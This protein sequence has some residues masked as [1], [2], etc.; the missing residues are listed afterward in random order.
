MNRLYIIL[1]AIVLSSC[2]K[3]IDLDLAKT[4]PKIVIESIVT[5]LNTRHTVAISTTTNFESDNTKVPVANATV[6]LK[7]GSGLT[8]NFTEQS[9]GNYISSRYRGVPGEKYTLTVTADGKSYS[10]TSVMPLPVPIK[11]LEQIEISFFGETRK[12]VQVNYKDPAGAVNFYNNRVFVNNIKRGDYYLD[13]D[14]FNN[15]NEVKNTLYIDEPDLVAG[16]LV[17]VQ[18]LTIDENVYKFLFSITQITGNG[19]PPTVPANPTSNFN[20]GALGYF[21]AS[22]SSEATITIK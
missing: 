8:I 16:D 12:A 15:G 10:A 13:S 6:V 4:E 20:N 21:S 19:G 7:T 9:P 3:V 5:D 2:E 17:R 18:M 1:L 22:T 14:R 11:S